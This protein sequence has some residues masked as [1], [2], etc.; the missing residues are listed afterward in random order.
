MQKT[1]LACALA[2]ALPLGAAYAADT[3]DGN[4]HGSGEAGLAI[5][6]GN[7]KSQNLNAK[8]TL[9]K[10]D[11]QW[12]YDFFLEALRN[13]ADV[14]SSTTYVNNSTNPPT[15]TTV[16]DKAYQLT[17]NRYDAGASAG[18]K[19][20]E[21][22]YI[23]GAVRYDHDAFS[24]YQYQ[25]VVSIGYGYQVLKNATD[26]LSFE[27]GPGYRVQQPRSYYGPV[28][29]PPV[30]SYIKEDSNN[31]LVGRG[32]VSYKHNFNDTT[33]F[34]NTL[35]IESG[36]GN[37]FVQNDAGLQVKMSDKL[38]LKAGYQVRHNSSIPVGSDFTK[39]T[40]QLLTTN[41]VYGF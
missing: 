2:L 20:D 7:A 41:L 27:A 10:E 25:Y 37:T 21:R 30:I 40:D 19:L 29:E 34:V 9:K 5:A 23:V 15:Q 18:Y 33:S 11:E 31:S 22:S 3:N 6:S 17:S 36:D 4:W 14:S 26:E 13:K 38:A 24:P 16:T 1:N 28:G 39:K 32:L 8:L 35:L 12:K